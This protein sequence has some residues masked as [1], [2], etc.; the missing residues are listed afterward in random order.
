MVEKLLIQSRGEEQPD[1]FQTELRIT[2]VATA[3]QWAASRVKQA[4]TV[5]D[6]DQFGSCRSKSFL[7][8]R[9]ETVVSKRRA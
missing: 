4:H 5:S 9:P 6:I 3:W 8:R 7:I 2:F 1:H